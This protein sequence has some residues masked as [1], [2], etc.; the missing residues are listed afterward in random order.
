MAKD[1]RKTATQARILS[2]SVEMFGRH[3]FHGATVQAVADRAGISTGTVHWH[4]ST[5]DVLYAEAAWEA[6]E[7]FLASI[8]RSAPLPFT[9][10]AQRWI[11]GMRNRTATARL[12]RG[13][14][15][16]LGN[17]TVAEAGARVN[18]RFVEYWCDWFREHAHREGDAHGAAERPPGSLVVALLTGLVATAGEANAALLKDLPDLV[19]LIGED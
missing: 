15:G 16:H 12:L 7:R 3:G 2:A 19:A 8:S 6:A 11:A 13:L 14:S 17:P 9:A 10:L 4:F 18:D 1:D 5:K